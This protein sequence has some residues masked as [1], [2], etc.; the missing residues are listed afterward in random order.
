MFKIKVHLENK[1]NEADMDGIEIQ[2]KCVNNLN[3]D[4]RKSEF[5]MYK[6]IGFGRKKSLD[7]NDVDF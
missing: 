2:R 5:N 7:K 4:K 6:N 3:N 1:I